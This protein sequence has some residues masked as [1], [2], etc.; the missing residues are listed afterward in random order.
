[1]ISSPCKDC[2]KRNLP[3][4]ECIE[5]CE[6]IRTLQAYIVSQGMALGT[7]SDYTELDDLRAAIPRSNGGYSHQHM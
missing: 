1:M 3:K 7:S 5:F 2:P 4:D 6:K